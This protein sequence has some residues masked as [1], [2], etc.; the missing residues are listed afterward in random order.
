VEEAIVMLEKAMKNGGED[1]PEIVDHMCELLVVAGRSDEAYHICK[2]A[3]ELNNKQETVEQKIN[4][5]K[6]QK[7][8]KEK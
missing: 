4:S 1:N 6:E 5:I 2:Y 8:R 7:N 3:V